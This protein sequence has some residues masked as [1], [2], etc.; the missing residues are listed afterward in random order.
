MKPFLSLFALISLGLVIEN[1]LW[2]D[3]NINYL[4]RLINYED[5]LD[6]QRLSRLKRKAFAYILQ[7][8]IGIL[9]LG[10]S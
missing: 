10:I 3:R 9:F 1:F 8:L 6:K 7:K 2:S 4:S 5:Q